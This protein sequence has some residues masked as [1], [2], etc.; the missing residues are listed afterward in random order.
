MWN[1]DRIQVQENMIFKIQSLNWELYEYYLWYI[2][3]L[4]WVRFMDLKY[5]LNI[6]KW[7]YR[8]FCENLADSAH[9]GLKKI[10]CAYMSPTGWPV[11]GTGWLLLSMFAEN[12]HFLKIVDFPI[13]FT[14]RSCSKLNNCLKHIYE[15]IYVLFK[16]MNGFNIFWDN[17]LK[18]RIKK[19]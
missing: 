16:F 17:N 1:E 8:F 14:P 9:F 7:V 4:E 11:V 15:Y 5:I 3:D 10:H 12:I 13:W 6:W 19:I 2:K 18:N